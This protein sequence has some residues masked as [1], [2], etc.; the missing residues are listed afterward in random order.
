MHS[1][2]HRGERPQHT[3]PLRF[4]NLSVG[5]RRSTLPRRARQLFAY[6][7]IACAGFAEFGRLAA[8]ILVFRGLHGFTRLRLA[9][10]RHESFDPEDYSSDSLVPLHVS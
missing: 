9:P 3:G 7:P 10:S 6:V 8:L 2:C 1:C 4:L 5:T